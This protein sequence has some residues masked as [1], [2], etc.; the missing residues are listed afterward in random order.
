MIKEFFKCFIAY[1]LTN[2]LVNHIP[3]FSFRHFYYRTV[4]GIKI[5]ERSAIHLHLHVIGRKI[6]I[7]N[8]TIIN[9]NCLLDGRGSILIG[10][11]VSISPDVHLISGSH[12]VNSSDF[13][14]CEDA[15]VIHD[16]AWIGSRATILKG[17]TIGEGAVVGVGA[18][19]TKSVNPYSIVGGVPAVE[20]GKRN[21]NLNYTL[22]CQPFFN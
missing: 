2:H 9:R 6:R 1:Y 15:I 5:G 10:N 16:Y 3:S 7:G 21:M 13:E 17:V 8:H 18:V 12:D 22:D 11:N 4:K 20:I 19:V 14:Y